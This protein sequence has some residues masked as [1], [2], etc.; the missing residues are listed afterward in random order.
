MPISAALSRAARNRASGSVGV[1]G[2][3]GQ[4]TLQEVLCGLGGIGRRHLPDG[5]LSGDII[6]LTPT[7]IV[8]W[9]ID[10]EGTQARNT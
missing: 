10:G 6:R 1:R 4:Q 7:R 8:S 3:S 9:G 5:G 2:P